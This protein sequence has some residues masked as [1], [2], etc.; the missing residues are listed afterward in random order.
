M[1]RKK[2][3]K[4]NLILDAALKIIGERGLHALTM[5]QVAEVA[6][7][8]TGT[9]YLY[10]KNKES[11]CAAV[12]AKLNKEVNHAIS[13]K[14]DQVQTG[15]EKIMACGIA[16]VEF[17]FS[18]PQRAKAF[19]DLYQMEIKDT[20][21]PNVQELIK[22]V[23]KTLRI[24]EESFRQAINE[25]SVR[26]DLDPIPAAMFLRMAFINALTP[27]SEQVLLLKSNKID[28]GRYLTTVQDMVLRTTHQ[29]LPDMEKR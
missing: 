23:N 25:G 24:K 14:M 26:K 5:E 21:D 28:M 11:L 20:E 12:S 22:E 17:A 3:E 10:F 27:T 18:D 6:D 9:L 4:R 2:E 15:S 13:E 1:K 8:A 16:I 7:V 29:N 19:R